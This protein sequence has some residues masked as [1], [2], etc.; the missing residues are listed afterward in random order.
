VPGL[1]P[2]QFVLALTAEIPGDVMVHNG[3]SFS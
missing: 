2:G 3:S 1:H